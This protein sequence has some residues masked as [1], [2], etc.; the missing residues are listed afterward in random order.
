M[1]KNLFIL[2]ALLLPASLCAQSALGQA[3]QQ[4]ESLTGMSIHD[5]KVPDP[6]DPVPVDPDPE[7]DSVPRLYE[8]VTSAFVEGAATYDGYLYDAD[9]NV[10]G[11]VQVKRAKYSATKKL[12]KVTASVTLAGSRKKTFTGGTWRM[13]SEEVVLSAKK[14]TRELRVVLG[15]R[16]LA[17]TYGEYFI[18]G[19]LNP[20]TSKVSA[21]KADGAAV[22]DGIKK[23]GKAFLLAVPS[24]TGWSGLT[25]SMKTLGKVSVTGTLADGKRVSITSQL[26]IGEE[27][28]CIP[29]VSTK[30]AKPAFAV[31]LT[32]DGS[33]AGVVG[34][35]DAKFSVVK[36]GLASGATFN[37]D[38]TALVAALGDT[39][40]TDYLPN[41][42]SVASVGTKWQVEN[43]AKAGAVKLNKKTGELT[44]TSANWAAL[45]LT[46]KAKT[47]Q[48][49]G[50]FKAYTLAK[51]RLKSTTVKVAGVL[52]DGAGYGTA[53][54]KKKSAA[55]TVAPKNN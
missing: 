39:L 32:R 49:S 53:T 37:V 48:F 7:E 35:E 19:A 36:A 38:E 40:L 13:D 17:G 41:G 28:C 3:L 5:I 16:G 4:L 43:G 33:S 45:K 1:K 23:K 42:F 25:V 52:V 9:D 15:A 22:L 27:L 31:W 20:F 26:L 46:C 47:G 8:T 54:V 29:V 51:G 18:D 14:D 2:A 24:D 10:V 6:G 12:A 55:V 30:F 50:S 11:V 34:L 44:T 21:V